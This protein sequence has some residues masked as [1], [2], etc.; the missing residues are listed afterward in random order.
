M[1]ILTWN[2]L[3]SEWIKKS[4]Y[5]SVKEKVLFDRKSRL[6]RIM[7]RII[8]EDPD[9]LLLQEVMELEYK[10]LCKHLLPKYHISFLSPID[11][12]KKQDEKYIK[13]EKKEEKKEEKEITSESGNVTLLKKTLFKSKKE[14]HHETLPMDF[15]VYTTTFYQSR[16]IHIFNIHLNDLHSQRRNIQM[17]VLRPFLDKQKYCIIAG[18]FNQEYR[19][20]SKLYNITNFTV[21]NFCHTYYI[22]KNMNIDN[23][24]TKGFSEK[25]EEK[26]KNKCNYVPLKVENGFKIYGSDHLPVMILIKV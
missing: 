2:I 8:D 12:A 21:H 14:I 22:E 6:K 1:K 5:P 23:I 18:D 4:Y 13:K 11:W 19:P 3:A 25:E 7:E 16:Q 20:N 9:I 17:N 15:G 10:T 26:N 24:L